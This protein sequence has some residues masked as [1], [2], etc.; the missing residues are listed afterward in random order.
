MAL[1]AHEH[2]I[3]DVGEGLLVRMQ[4]QAQFPVVDIDGDDVVMYDRGDDGSVIERY[5]IATSDLRTASRV[6]FWMRQLAPKTW[7]T[8]RH[9]ELLA[10]T[11]YRLNGGTD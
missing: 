4:H 2:T 6:A 7:V 8:T 10:S 9:L 1:E 11:V 5:Y 3:G